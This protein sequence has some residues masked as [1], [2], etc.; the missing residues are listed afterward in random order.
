[1]RNQNYYPPI[2]PPTFN[3]QGGNVSSGFQVTLSNPN[4]G[5]TIY[6]T[7]DSS[8]PRLSGGALNPAAQ[9]YQSPIVISSNTRIRTRVLSNS[10]WS[11]LNDA[12]FTIPSPSPTPAP[13]GGGNL[14]VFQADN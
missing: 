12:T 9:T 7:T 6:Y 8:D 1:L 2:N 10:T 3:R 13:F 11:A 14:A 4:S 5:G